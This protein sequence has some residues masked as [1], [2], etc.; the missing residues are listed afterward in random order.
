MPRFRSIAPTS[1]STSLCLEALN[2]RALGQN[3]NKPSTFDWMLSR[4]R[5]GTQRN[6]PRE[7]IHLL[8]SLRDEQVRRLEIGD[9]EPDGPRLFVR[10]TFKDA[11]VIDDDA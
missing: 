9:A 11:L 10:A 5:D 4:T 3:V 1:D 7:L 6:A 2:G 8:N